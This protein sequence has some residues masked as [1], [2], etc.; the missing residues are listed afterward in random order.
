MLL[1]LWQLLAKKMEVFVIH[2]HRSFLDLG[3]TF[4]PQ[5]GI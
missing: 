4:L 3:E 5:R 2:G 1:S